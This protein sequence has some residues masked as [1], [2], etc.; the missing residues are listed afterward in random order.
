LTAEFMPRTDAAEVWTLVKDRLPVSYDPLLLSFYRPRSRIDEYVAFGDDYGTE[1]WCRLTDGSVNSVD[2]NRARRTRFVNSGIDQLATFIEV[3][4]AHV[5]MEKSD[6]EAA[7]R[8][9]LMRDDL[10]AID[11]MAFHDSENWWAVALEQ[12][13]DGLL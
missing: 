4:R 13:E 1:L 11:P 6:G 3:Y 7:T 5:S 10:A 2:P 12:V 8:A 9:R